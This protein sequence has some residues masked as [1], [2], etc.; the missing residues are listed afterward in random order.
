MIERILTK[1]GYKILAIVILLLVLHYFNKTEIEELK[2]P[3][4]II[5]CNIKNKGWI[6]IDK[7]K[8]TGIMDDGTIQFTNGYAKNCKIYK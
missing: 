3:N 8:I 2:N 7:N 1:P 6:E 5:E 4:T